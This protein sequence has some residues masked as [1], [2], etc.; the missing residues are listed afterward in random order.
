MFSDFHNHALPGIDDGASTLDES[1]EMIR[2]L[3]AQDVRRIIL[4]PHFSKD[5][6][7]ALFLAERKKAF[8]PLKSS[9]PSKMRI[10]LAAE[11]S[12]EENISR[13]VELSKLTVD[14]TRYI[15]LRLPYFT[16]DEWIDYELH[17]VLYKHR[18][19]PVFTSIDRYRHTYPKEKFDKI[20][21][22]PDAVFQF[23]IKSFSDKEN[24]KVLK[25]LISANKT[26]L[27]GSNAHNMSTRKPNFDILKDALENELGKLTYNYLIIQNNHFL[28]PIKKG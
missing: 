20:L 28:D 15:M 3:Y 11:V 18:L 25:R 13:E 8:L 17:N 12:L 24:I 5:Q 26:V 21:S 27:L 14:K 16:F 22:T 10:Q 19:I 1:V 4:T 2:L 23:N 6:N 7:L 9:V